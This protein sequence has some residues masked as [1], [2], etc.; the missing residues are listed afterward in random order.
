[1]GS[2]TPDGRRFARDIS[3]KGQRSLQYKTPNLTAQKQT[4]MGQKLYP[5]K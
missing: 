4:L 2:N 1:M 5:I 3:T